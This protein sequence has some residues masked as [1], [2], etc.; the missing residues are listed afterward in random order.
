MSSSGCS[1]IVPSM[2]ANWPRHD[3][4]RESSG[5]T[6]S[7][8]G[9]VRSLPHGGDQWCHHDGPGWMACTH[10][11]L[12]CVGDETAMQGAGQELGRGISIDRSKDVASAIGASKRKTGGLE[13]ARSANRCEAAAVGVEVQ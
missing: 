8:G 4:N 7:L 6:R 11:V 3:P 13:A 1:S 12:Q 5:M 9:G 10:L 2:P